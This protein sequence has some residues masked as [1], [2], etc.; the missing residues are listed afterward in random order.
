MTRARPVR[1]ERSAKIER[2]HQ[3]RIG[4]YA[5]STAKFRRPIKIKRLDSVFIFQRVRLSGALPSHARAALGF[6]RG[7]VGRTSSQ[8][9]RE[10]G[11]E[12]ATRSLYRRAS[13]AEKRTSQFW[14]NSHLV[15]RCRWT[16]VS[17]NTL[18]CPNNRIVELDRQKLRVARPRSANRTKPRECPETETRKC[19]KC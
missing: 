18:D 8:S 10:T 13:S 5:H 12:Q 1:L 2:R 19:T 15:C 6:G 9:A 4:Y 17:T 7:A 11:R 3:N 14:L 16:R